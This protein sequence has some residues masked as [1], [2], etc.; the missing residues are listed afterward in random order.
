MPHWLLRAGLLSCVGFQNPLGIIESGGSSP[1]QNV[2]CTATLS[3]ENT[4]GGGP[5]S[6]TIQKAVHVRSSML[7][8]TPFVV[9]AGVA[10][11]LSSLPVERWVQ[12]GT[13]TPRG[14]SPHASKI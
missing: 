14:G 5:C 3:S 12:A 1:P 4:G 10:S 11:E 9:L 2:C 6:Q 13:Q 8:L 7:S